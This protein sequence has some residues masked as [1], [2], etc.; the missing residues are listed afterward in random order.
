M[1]ALSAIIPFLSLTGCGDDLD[2]FPDDLAK[3]QRA[4]GSP[5]TSE[6]TSPKLRS[7][8]Y[9]TWQDQLNY[10]INDKPEVDFITTRGLK[11]ESYKLLS[12]EEDFN[13]GIKACSFFPFYNNPLDYNDYKILPLSEIGKSEPDIVNDLINYKERVTEQYSKNDLRKVQLNWNYKNT[14]FM[15]LCLVTDE[16]IVYDDLLSHIYVISI[17][18]PTEIYQTPRLKNGNES[19]NGAIA[20]FFN[21][22]SCS[23]S[24]LIGSA[25]AWVNVIV[26]GTK[27]SG[28]KS[29]TEYSPYYYSSTSGYGYEADAS[30]DILEFETVVNGNCCFKWEVYV[31]QK[32]PLGPS[33]KFGSITN[34][35]SNMLN[36]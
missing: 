30:L 19:D 17:S 31:A 6:E 33:K 12:D 28:V 36:N 4:V 26:H 20:Y 29:I 11:L 34:V 18:H 8:S 10:L 25:V 15:T 23:L 2:F 3:I 14:E 32:S 13:A 27:S 5:T 7:F 1:L 9:D 35:T 24:S 22:P 16:K 21:S